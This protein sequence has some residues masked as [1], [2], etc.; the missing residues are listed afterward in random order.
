MDTNIETKKI[1]LISVAKSPSEHERGLQHV[2]ELPDK[3]GMLFIFDHSMPRSFWM[4]NCALP[5]EIAFIDKE[6]KII[7]IQEMIPHSLKPVSSER[8]CL[9]A[10][11]VMAKT[12]E[13]LG[14]KVGHK[15][16]INWKDRT[17]SIND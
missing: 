1:K 4:K 2:K 9:M 15:I 13:K 5:L 7:K 14:A 12:L 16:Q 3:A 11:E 17:V 10:L 8:P 6:N